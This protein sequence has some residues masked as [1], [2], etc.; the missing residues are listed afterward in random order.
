[1]SPVAEIPAATTVLP[2]QL[3]VDNVPGLSVAIPKI[4]SVR[5]APDDRANAAKGLTNHD[6]VGVEMAGPEHTQNLDGCP[7]C[8]ARN[9]APHYS[10]PADGGVICHYVCVVCGCDWSTSWWGGDV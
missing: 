8:L 4:G 5:T 9:N 6:T 2:S 10:T 7:E 1:M 3:P